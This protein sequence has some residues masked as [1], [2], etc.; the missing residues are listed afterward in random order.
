MR[1][2]LSIAAAASIA[3]TILCLVSPS[4]SGPLAEALEPGGAAKYLSCIVP[5]LAPHLPSSTHLFQLLLQPLVVFKASCVPS[6]FYL[7]RSESYLE[8]SSILILG[9]PAHTWH[10]CSC[11]ICHHLWCTYAVPGSILHSAVTCCTI[12]GASLHRLN[13]W[14]HLVWSSPA[15]IDLLLRVCS[16]AEVISISVLSCRTS[17]LNISQNSHLSLVDAVQG[18]VLSL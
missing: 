6:R 14:Y 7:C 16:C 18:I 1:R 3:L 10:R 15:S 17:L 12:S 11:I 5:S 8:A 4:N 2:L 13:L 9:L